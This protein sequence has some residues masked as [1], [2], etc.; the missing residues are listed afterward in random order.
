M[1]VFLCGINAKYIHTNLAIRQIK[2]Y[3][4]KRTGYKISII[5]YTINNYV[6]EIIEGIYIKKPDILGFSCYLWNIEIVQKLVVILKKLLPDI[7]IILG[8]PEVTYN[9]VEILDDCPCDY[10]ISGEGEAVFCELLTA[11]L[12]GKIK[13]KNIL[14]LSYHENNTVITNKKNYGFDMAELPFPYDN[15]A[16]IENKICYYEASRGC[17]FGCK[18]CLSS[19]EKGVRFAPIEKVC[20]ELKIFIDNKVRQVKFVDRTFNCKKEF[21]MGIIKFL[22]ENDNEITNFHFE[23]AAELLDD[24]IISL[25]STARSGLFQLEIG[26]QSTNEN[27][28]SAIARK[29][30]FEWLSACVKKLKQANNMHLHLDLIA[31]LPLEN[32]ESFKK[33]FNDVHNLFPHQLQLGFLK[34]LKGSDMEI[35]CDDFKI[36]HSPF[37]PYEILSTNCLSFDDVLV[38][39]GIEEMVEIYYNTNR[40]I[41]S[42]DYLCKFF[43][44]YF[45]F[46]LLLSSYKKEKSI[47]SL[48][49]NKQTSYAFLIEFA[50]EKLLNCNLIILICVLKL[51]LLLHEKPRSLPSW[52]EEISFNIKD[53]AYNFIV[54]ENLALSLLPEYSDCDA[55]QLMRLVQIEKFPINP[56][57]F[58]EIE[59]SLL[60]NYRS[61]NLWGNAKAIQIELK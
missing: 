47:D 57:T 32:L 48:V 26:V 39:K 24:E 42:V 17:P 21:A 41:N 59:T 20:G 43:D 36:E 61:R 33:S 13:V 53:E 35:M 58:E 38:L 12:N 34:I 18:Y 8:G 22:I 51:D 25:L 54:K 49:H 19:V 40:Y 9:P 52:A 3:V 60:F 7:I 5:E 31:G 15:F 56:Y 14:G 27:T 10:V 45:D 6:N 1:N 4:E 2:G 16:E 23:V 50:K 44:S 46:Y 11:I 30:N 55:K 37:P 29:S 28:L